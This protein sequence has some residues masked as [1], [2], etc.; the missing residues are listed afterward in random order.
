MS[1]LGEFAGMSVEA[2]IEKP[3]PT[4]NE[5]DRICTPIW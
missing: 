5:N 3:K 4:R 1:S 2:A